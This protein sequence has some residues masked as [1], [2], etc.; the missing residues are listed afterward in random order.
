MYPVATLV[1]TRSLQV[2]SSTS[3]LCTIETLMLFPHKGWPAE[4]KVRARGAEWLK[5]E[6]QLDE[7]STA[8]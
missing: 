7:F 4:D 5:M 1:K 8:E 3:R 2:R 6:V